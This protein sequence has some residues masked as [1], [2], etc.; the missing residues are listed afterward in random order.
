MAL[1][2]GRLEL[3]NISPLVLYPDRVLYIASRV[4]GDFRTGNT[5]IAFGF[6]GEQ[7]WKRAMWAPLK[8]TCAGRQRMDAGELAPWVAE[9]TRRLRQQGYTS[10]TVKS[11]DDAA[12]HHAHWLLK[13]RSRSPTS[14]RPSSIASRGIVA[15]VRVSGPRSTSPASTCGG[16]AGSSSSSASARPRATE[17]KERASGARK[18][19]GKR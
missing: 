2:R 17:G 13:A 8:A 15:S 10:L 19:E 9:F 12:R 16:S 11:Y 18:R 3:D 5:V 4:T 6:P 7:S 1:V 14:T